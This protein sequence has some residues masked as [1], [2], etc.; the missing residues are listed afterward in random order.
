MGGLSLYWTISGPSSSS[1]SNSNS[2]SSTE[3][4]AGIGPGSLRIVGS[5]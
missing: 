5:F 2:N 1:S 4:R 3:L